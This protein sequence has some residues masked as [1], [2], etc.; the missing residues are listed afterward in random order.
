MVQ[1]ALASGEYVG[2]LWMEGSPTVEETLYWLGLLIDTDLPIAGAASQRPHGQL[3][4]DGDRNLVDAVDYILSGPGEWLGL[5]RGA[6]RA[7]LCQPRVQEGRR[8]ARQLQGHRGSRRDTGHRGAAG[9][10]L[11]PAQLP[12]HIDVLRPADSPSAA[13]RVPGR[14]RRRLAHRHRHQGR[15]RGAAGSRRVPSVHIVEVRRVHAGGR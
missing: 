14:R 9:H 6:G 13:A 8:Q 7:A 4:N 15:G 5:S 1:A 12:P 10:R 3:A 2:G 11:V